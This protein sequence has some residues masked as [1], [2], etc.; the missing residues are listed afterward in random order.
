MFKEKNPFE[1][2]FSD[3]KNSVTSK[4]SGLNVTKKSGLQ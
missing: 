2:E 1:A 3:L 4:K